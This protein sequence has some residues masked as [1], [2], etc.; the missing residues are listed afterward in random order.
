MNDIAHTE[1]KWKDYNMECLCLEMSRLQFQ[2][3]GNLQSLK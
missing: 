2:K 1:I 3:I